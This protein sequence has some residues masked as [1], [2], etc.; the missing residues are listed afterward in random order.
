VDPRYL[1]F[2]G[3]A[4]LDNGTATLPELGGNHLHHFRAFD[5]FGVAGRVQMIGKSIGCEYREHRVRPPAL[6]RN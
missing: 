3:S 6:E 5:A 1:V 4:R 2:G